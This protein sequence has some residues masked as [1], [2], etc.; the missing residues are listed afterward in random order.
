MR[1]RVCSRVTINT[2]VVVEV[3]ERPA[4]Q[5]ARC[6]LFRNILNCLALELMDLDGAIFAQLW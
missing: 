4:V 1:T 2:P 5:V 3:E 6:L